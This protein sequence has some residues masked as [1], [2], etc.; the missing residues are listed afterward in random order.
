[1]FK[2]FF[3]TIG[4]DF[5]EKCRLTDPSGTKALASRRSIPPVF[6]YLCG[7][8][9][10]SAFVGCLHTELP[11]APQPG[12]DRL[13]QA[14]N[15]SIPYKVAASGIDSIVGHQYVLFIFPFGRIG[16]QSPN[17]WLTELV[18]HQLAVAGFR[19]IPSASDSPAMLGVELTE[20]SVS[21][22]DFFF[23]RSPVA[24]VAIKVSLLGTDGSPRR[25]GVGLGTA[26]DVTKFAFER[27]LSKVLAEASNAAITDGF[28]Q[29]GL[30]P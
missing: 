24:S 16:I 23:F 13:I 9:L 29:V 25:S 22:Y 10:L 3:D 17:E 30:I 6:N 26:R 20:L 1:M 19:P 15:R 18:V 21:G 7:F 14:N 8:L 28:K 12:I 2:G 4:S 27:E 5:I 11:H